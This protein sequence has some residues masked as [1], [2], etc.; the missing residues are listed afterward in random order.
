MAGYSGSGN[1]AFTPTT[2]VNGFSWGLEGTGSN[3]VID[4][5]SPSTRVGV[6]VTYDY[7]YDSPGVPEP[8]SLALLPMMFTGLMLWRRRRT[9]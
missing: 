2:P 1:V 8:T 4:V 9:A 7:D 5:T 6:A 3:A